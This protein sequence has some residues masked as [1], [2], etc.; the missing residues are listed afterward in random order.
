MLS[1]T[2]SKDNDV[3]FEIDPRPYQIAL[4]KE[5]ANL[6]NTIQQLGAQSSSVKAAASSVGVSE[7][8]LDR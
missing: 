7:A 1:F 6:D 4:E 3:I 5:Q 2:N 8:Q